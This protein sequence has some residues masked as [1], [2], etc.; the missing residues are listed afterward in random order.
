M[1]KPKTIIDFE[2]SDKLLN[3]LREINLKYHGLKKNDIV[4]SC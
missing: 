4:P 3:G 1:N 2:L